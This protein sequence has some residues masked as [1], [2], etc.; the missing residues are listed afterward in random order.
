[1]RVLSDPTLGLVIEA[2]ADRFTGSELKTLMMRADVYQ[3]GEKEANKQELLRSR[4]LGA[5]DY[6]EEHGDADTRH[7]LLTLSACWSN[8][9]SVTRRMHGPGSVTSVRLS[10][11]T[12]MS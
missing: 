2:A 6:A 11:R 4:L 3:Y 9:L 7:A 10:L 12:A 1:M 5:R 8:G